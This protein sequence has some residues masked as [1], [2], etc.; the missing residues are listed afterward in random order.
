MQNGDGIT[1]RGFIKSASAT[2]AGAAAVSGLGLQGCENGIKTVKL[3]R[4]DMT[5]STFLG[6]RMADRKM[7]EMALA[8]GVNYWHKMGAW[9]DPAPYELFRKLD[10]D[11]WYCDTVVGSLDKEK[12]IEIFEGRLKKTGLDRID[13]FKIHS[14]YRSA[15]DVKNKMGAIQA[16]EELKKQ[17]KTRYLMMSQ[18]VNTVEVFEAAIESEMFDLIQIPVNPTVP[19]D[20]FT[21]QEFSRKATQDEYL[22]LIKKAADKGIAVTAMKVFL[23]GAKNWEQFPELKDRVAKYLPDNQSI[24]T[25][26]IHWTLNVPGV[27]AYGSMLYTFDELKENLAAVGGSLSDAED[28]G[29][30]VFR[31]CIDR[32]YCRMCGACQRANP[33]RLAVSDILRFDGYYKGFGQESVARNLYAS[34][35]PECRVE[36][37]KDLSR[38]EEAC[39]Y[40]LPLVSMLREAQARLG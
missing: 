1:R 29:L 24:A 20:Y 8:A 10:R 32:G 21:K 28:K 40:G 7:Y 39:P 30:R 12:C 33:G 37:V 23:Y 17:G 5:V 27:Q 19:K 14:Q 26:L 22:G 2:A 31:D 16:F 9:V 18:H 13:G 34:L 15:E 6:D 3:G 36:A 11:S 38:Y 25:A 4:T 35:P